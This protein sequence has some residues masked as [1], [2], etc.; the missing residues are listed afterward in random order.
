M[1][2]SLR[3]LCISRDEGKCRK[4]QRHFN[5]RIGFTLHHVLPQRLNGP[6][7]YFN[8][9]CLCQQC[10]QE[11]HWYEEDLDILWDAKKT[12]NEF[13]RWL[14]SEHLQED[15]D[16]HGDCMDYYLEDFLQ[17]IVRDLQ[18]TKKKRK[19]PRNLRQTTVPR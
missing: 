10:H 16:Y 6:D 3:R 12:V 9:V 11:W 8:L 18:K 1:R 14:R 19:Q 13:Y 7:E 2:E 4:C 17:Q 5:K 15:I